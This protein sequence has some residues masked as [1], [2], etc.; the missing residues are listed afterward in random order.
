MIEQTMINAQAREK[1]FEIVASLQVKST[2]LIEYQSRGRVVVI[3]DEEAMEF[4]PRLRDH[5]LSPIVLLTGGS[6]EA[7]EVVVPVGGRKIVIQG[8]LGNFTIA[9]GEPGKPNFE[10]LQTD[11]LLDLSKQPLLDMEIKPPGYYT[12][13][14]SDEIN[15]L[16]TL[17]QLQEMKGTFEKP[18]YFDYDASICAHSRSGQAGCTRCIDACPTQAITSLAEAI[19][20]NPYLCQGG[21]VCDTVCPT[22]AIRYVYPD[23]KDTMARIRQ[24]L[25]HYHDEGGRAPVVAFIST[26]DYEQVG[27]WP[28]GMLPIVLEELASVGMDVWLSALAYGASAVILVDAGSVPDGVSSA[29]DEQLGFSKSLLQG[30]NYGSGLIQMVSVDDLDS[31]AMPSM[32]EIKVASYAGNKEK[33]RTLYSAI[34]HLIKYAGDLA[35]EIPLPMN[36]P[37]GRIHVDGERCTMCMGC[38][39]VCPTT[40][41]QAGNDAPPRLLFIETICVQCGLCQSACPE[42]AIHLQPRLLTDLEQ[43]RSKIIL[44]EELPFNCIS[45][46]K[47]FATQSIINTILSKLTEHA[48]FQSERSKQRL[49]MCEDCRVVDAV[50]DAD[51]MQAGLNVKGQDDSVNGL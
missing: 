22:G 35:D 33:R 15:L 38:T 9:V 25:Q 5:K 4:A 44:H 37:F 29:I 46:G 40:A 10:T 12:A 27:E 26:D 24:L 45:C 1:A 47:P 11:L 7:G 23:A 49:K 3:G 18:R 31:L 20:V 39:A 36:A 42:Q 51:A 16:N 13:D 17:N 14:T 34:D 32:S 30:M 21:G 28:D 6:V 19:E 41:V 48:M 8:Y 2:D 43:R 50:Q